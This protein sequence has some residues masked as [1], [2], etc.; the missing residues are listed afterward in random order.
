MMLPL[1]N[2]LPDLGSK[3]VSRSFDG[4]IKVVEYYGSTP[5]V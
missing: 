2:K 4:S 1:C 5:V 3:N